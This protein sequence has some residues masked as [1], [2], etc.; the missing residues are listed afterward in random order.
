MEG[1]EE[2]VE[3][4]EEEAEAEKEGS[5]SGL[6][7]SGRRE[8]ATDRRTAVMASPPCAPSNPSGGSEDVAVATVALSVLDEGTEAGRT[9][10]A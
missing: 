9:G 3:E 8:E 4:E 5:P 7:L 1:R 10:A 2:E 6:S